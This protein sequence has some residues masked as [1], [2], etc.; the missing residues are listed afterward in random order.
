[1]DDYKMNQKEQHLLKQ[2]LQKNDCD[3]IVLTYYNMIFYTVKKINPSYTNEDIEDMTQEIFIQL[4]KD[5]C[6]KLRQYNYKKGLSL[7]GWIRMIATRT[8]FNANRKKRIKI[9]TQFDSLE[10]EIWL[11]RNAYN[12]SKTKLSIDDMEEI[13]QSMSYRD[14]LVLKL[15]YIK[16][17][18]LDEISVFMKVAKRQLYYI[19]SRAVERLKNLY[20]KQMKNNKKTQNGGKS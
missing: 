1:M 20:F 18:T 17:L 19:K 12:M 15:F 10:E 3:S 7:S 4:F 16:G 8:V 11:D 9:S 2:C 13:I 5:D 6:K 14:Q